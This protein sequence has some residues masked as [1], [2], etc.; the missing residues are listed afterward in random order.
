MENPLMKESFLLD[1]GTISDQFIKNPFT[2]N[3]GGLHDVNKS[4]K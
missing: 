4:L 3:K 1:K 2:K